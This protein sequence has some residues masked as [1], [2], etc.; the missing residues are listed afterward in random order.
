MGHR[1]DFGNGDFGIKAQAPATLT[2]LAD[3]FVLTTVAT[4]NGDSGGPLLIDF[5]GEQR[6]VG[7]TSHGTADCTDYSAAM[8][9]DLVSTW[10]DAEVA[11]LDPPSC[12]LD[13]RCV[14]DCAIVDPDCAMAPA[15]TAL[16]TG[17]CAVAGR[18]GGGEPLALLA[19][20]LL[21]GRKRLRLTAL[22]GLVLAAGCSGNPAART[23]CVARP[24]GS[25]SAAPQAELAVIGGDGHVHSV[26]SSTTVAAP[27]TSTRWS[28][29]A[30][31]VD[32]C[33]VAVEISLAAVDGTP[34]GQAGTVAQLSAP[35]GG[36]VGRPAED[37]GFSF[38]EL[39][40][41]PGDYT[42][43]IAIEDAAGRA[44][45]VAQSFSAR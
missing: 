36:D 35:D 15:A 6:I 38:V 39:P 29:F 1:G 34:A 22:I 8:R 26:G 20:L 18:R 32:G 17:G 43:T 25:T 19:V 28:I 11:A 24:I 16:A 12:R 27:P 13:G 45:L 9:V 30:R 41:A 7:V 2:D 14:A 23:I 5:A 44:A 31:N 33:A 3:E 40:L 21:I 37:D 4:C 42:A 10:I